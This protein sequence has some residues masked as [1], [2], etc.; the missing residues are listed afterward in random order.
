MINRR[1]LIRFSRL[2]CSVLIVAGLLAIPALHTT[3]RAQATGTSTVDPALAAPA[4]VVGAP[5][6]DV[7]AEVEV[8]E[9]EE[10]GT[11]LLV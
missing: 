4:A 3:A 9:A 8:D 7:G 2:M 11:A 1:R 10:V 6:V 5:T